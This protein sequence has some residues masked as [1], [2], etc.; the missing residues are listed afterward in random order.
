MRQNLGDSREP[1][2]SRCHLVSVCGRALRHSC[3]CGDVVSCQSSRRSFANA[4]W[5]KINGLGLSKPPVSQVLCRCHV[6]LAA[7]TYTQPSDMRAARLIARQNE[8]LATMAPFALTPRRAVEHH[9][10]PTTKQ[11]PFR[12]RSTPDHTG[13]QPI[14]MSEE[15]LAARQAAAE[16]LRCDCGLT[17]GA[18]T[19]LTAVCTRALLFRYTLHD[20]KPCSLQGLA[21]HDCVPL[22]ARSGQ[23][24]DDCTFS[25][26]INPTPRVAFREP[27][28]RADVVSAVKA[29]RC[30]V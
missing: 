19:Q 20:S 4:G 12:A 6:S 25:P 13:R 10:Q 17:E 24:P 3:R 30:T 27:L 23:L 22:T 18:L 1:S 14:E 15:M 28:T 29:V 26:A 11:K 9:P 2:R 8:L 16:V 5:Q 7:T 21:R